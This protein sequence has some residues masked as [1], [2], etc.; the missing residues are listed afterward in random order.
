MNRGY[1]Y[2]SDEKMLVTDESGN[3]TKRD[4]E[5]NNMHEV[6]QIENV[7]EDLAKYIEQVEEKNENE[8]K[9]NLPEKTLIYTFPFW[10]IVLL[11]GLLALAG[12]VFAPNEY[13]SLL[14]GGGFLTIGN[15]SLIIYHN[16]KDKKEKLATFLKLIKAQE[17]KEELNQRLT[18]IKIQSN[19][20]IINKKYKYSFKTNEIVSLKDNPIYDE[21][22]IKLDEAYQKGY[23]KDIK[24]RL[25]KK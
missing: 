14:V 10:F 8:P 12:Y 24:K 20:N 11:S 18:E 15:T 1:A 22:V 4:V 23:N 19:H 9:L 13:M 17:I 21:T 3:L 5:G 16:K 2:L 25:L 7:L 6:L